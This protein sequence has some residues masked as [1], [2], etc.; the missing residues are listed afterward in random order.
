M[1]EQHNHDAH[2][3]KALLL[4][5]AAGEEAAFRELVYANRKKL[6]AYTYKMTQSKELAEELVQDILMKIWVSREVLPSI[7]HFQTYLFVVTRNTCLNALRSAIRQ[8]VKHTQW[9]SEQP[10]SVESENQ[11]HYAYDLLEA[12]VN[13]LPPQQ[14]KVWMI[15]RK[16]G[17][18]QAAIA[19][20][21]GISKET[22]KRHIALANANI[23]QFIN[24]HLTIFLV[25][26]ANCSDW[27]NP[28]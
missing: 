12:A 1:V 9:I 5:I 13:A 7:H 14:K 26:T 24:S 4:R 16:E 23:V 25:L 11:Q 27:N 3:E 20:E 28:V 22:V 17:M 2:L 19:S 6:S 15:S 8:R 21:L 18:K 10:A